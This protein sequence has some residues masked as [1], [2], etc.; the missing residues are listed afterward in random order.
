MRVPLF[1]GL[2]YWRCVDYRSI[3]QV[4]SNKTHTQNLNDNLDEK[5]GD[6]YRGYWRLQDS[7]QDICSTMK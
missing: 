6:W 1:F 4:Y 7:S 2:I 3:Y 5:H